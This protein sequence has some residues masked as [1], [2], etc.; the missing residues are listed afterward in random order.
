MFR[1]N[2]DL[3]AWL[4]LLNM[5]SQLTGAQLHASEINRVTTERR[6]QRLA[7]IAVHGVKHA[8]TQGLGEHHEIVQ[9]GRCRPKLQF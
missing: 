9:C 7:E 3:P 6:D 1:H 5:I 8:G 2:T 4:H